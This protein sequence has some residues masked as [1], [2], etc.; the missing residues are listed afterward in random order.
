M[1]AAEDK[2]WIEAAGGI[3]DPP[4]QPPAGKAVRLA[5]AYGQAI[6]P[7]EANWRPLTTDGTRDL[8]PLTQERMQKVSHWLWE[9]NPLAN[10]IIELP[11]AYL[12][13][14][15]VKLTCDDPDNQK[16]LDRFWHD[17]INDM[18]VKLP[19][20][21]REL[22][23]FGEA[24]YPAFVR[25][26]DGMVRI[27]YL[28]P[29]A[30]GTVVTDPD[31]R[32]QPIGIV[33]KRDRKGNALRFKV[34]VNGDESVFTAHTQKIRET[35]TDG[36]LFYFRINDLSAG[37]RGRGDL[38]YQ[39]DWLDAYDQFLFGEVERYKM[40]RD[41]VWDLELKNASPDTVKQRAR[42]FVLPGTRGTYVHNDS[43]KLEPKVPD[44]SAADT[45]SG[46]R[47]LRNHML[48]GATIP[49]HWFGG[50]GDV[51]RAAAAE[52][53][54]P[55]FKVLAM[56]QR[57]LKHILESIGRYVLMKN[58]AKDGTKP[59]WGDKKWQV[60]AVFPELVSRDIAK[61]SQAMQQVVG[62]AGIAVDRH[63]VTEK[64]ALTLIANIA[65][66]LGVEI[67]AESELQAAQE[68]AAKKREA[69]N[70]VEPPPAGGGGA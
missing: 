21:V 1:S 41:L 53:G 60:K 29:I 68:E 59:D 54:E 40:L 70:F 24:A 67:D 45:S 8:T 16:A 55:A 46:A 19:K 18:D 69:D 14:D 37:T 17:A 58:G 49:E 52:M 38:L 26:E 48:G 13:A 51:N 5:E 10:R 25:N 57:V 61:I 42:D 39:A 11:V 44:L 56:R 62:A 2:F 50:G 35:F 63:L 22:A 9:Q 12:L 4:A 66:M 47:L 27:G 6:D 20:K 43:E 30:I 23:L 3:Y 65:A 34:I 31:N 36:E 15:G 28:D 7:D 64:T 33:T 32:E